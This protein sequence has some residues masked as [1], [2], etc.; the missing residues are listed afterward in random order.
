MQIT[1]EVIEHKDFKTSL[2]GYDKKE[3]D[4]FLDE[5]IEEFEDVLQ[6]NQKLKEEKEILL[7]QLAHY[8]KKENE[9]NETLIKAQESADKL[10]ERAK[11]DYEAKM[12]KANTM[13]QSANIDKY[14]QGK[15][16]EEKYNLLKMKY[17]KYRKTK[18]NDL[19][20]QLEILDRDIVE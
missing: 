8:K 2:R 20:K 11:A 14:E 19:R 18:K 15:K 17:L 16:L 1:P 9:L 7:N 13:L 12:K 6:K 4:I 5:I 3:V 10:V